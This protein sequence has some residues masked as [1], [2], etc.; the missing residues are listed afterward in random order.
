MAFVIAISVDSEMPLFA[1][2][3]LCLHCT[4]IKQ[5]CV[6]AQYTSNTIH[7]SD[8]PTFLGSGPGAC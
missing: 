5:Q 1:V 4:L 3:H 2:S 7:D 6:C 8:F